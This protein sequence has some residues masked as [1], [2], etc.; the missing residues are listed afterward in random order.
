M[1]E[2][3][4][5]ILGK[6]LSLAPLLLMCLV[7]MGLVMFAVVNVVPYVKTYQELQ[8]AADT[9]NSIIATKMAEEDPS[10]EI[11]ILQ[12]RLDTAKDSLKTSAN[13][14]META[15]ADA[16]LQK[17][18]DYAKASSVEIANLQ[19]QNTLNAGSQAPA[20]PTPKPSRNA[21][22][23]PVV[24][25]ATSAYSVRAIRIVANGSVTNLV[26]FLTRIREISV[27]GIAVNNLNIKDTEDPIADAVLTMDLLIYTSPLSD[28]KAY[29][30][31]PDVVLPTPLVVAEEATLA[32]EAVTALAATP[33]PDATAEPGVGS[34]TVVDT[35]SV[36][37]EPALN[38]V[39]TETFDSGNL[40]HWKLGAGWIFFKDEGS[41]SLQA[42]DN[43][44]DATF[45]FDTL[46][47][48]AVQ[49]RVLMSSSSIKL[50]LRQSS[51]GFYAVVLQPTGQIAL[52]RGATLI[53]ST[54]TD[55]SS[56]G[57]WRVLRLSVVEG[58][59]RIS[60][61]GEDVLTA[62]DSSELPPGTF[63]FST[64]GRGVVRVDDIDVFS[65]DTAEKF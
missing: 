49:L 3:R 24:V 62:R 13:L 46:D 38:P 39:Y 18:Y 21:T 50:T 31:L 5:P 47:N 65:L 42:S 58:I 12:H 2:A 37:P 6:I 30:D 48:S 41:P 29:L 60:V 44:G 56:I 26:R 51:A 52:Y 61:D 53:K 57:R 22:P 11:A 27:P 4:S 43:S 34:I 63:S 16:I 15:Q 14:F 17:L 59:I 19:T 33:A 1:D 20:A 10:G 8:L 32:P 54:T 28:G 45:A 64:I 40:N 55:Q 9:G 35:G 23:E 25:S 7:G 36:P